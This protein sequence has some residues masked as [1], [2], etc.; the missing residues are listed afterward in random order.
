MAHKPSKGFEAEIIANPIASV[1]IIA[2]FAYNDSKMTKSDA[3]CAGL[4]PKHCR[5][6]IPG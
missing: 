1:N 2:G 3:G 6:A 5:L 4:S